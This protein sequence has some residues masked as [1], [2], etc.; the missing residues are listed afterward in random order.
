MRFSQLDLAMLVPMI[1]IL[2]AVVATA[3][4]CSNCSISPDLPCRCDSVCNVYNDCCP[5][6]DGST[7]DD[8]PHHLREI[9]HLLQCESVLV[10]D[11]EVDGINEAYYMI[12]S[13]TVDGS[14]CGESVGLPPVTDVS[15]RLTYR[16]MYCAVCSG[17]SISSV[18]V[19]ST[20]LVC[21]DVIYDNVTIEVL[22]DHCSTCSYTQDTIEDVRWCIPTVDDCDT[23]Q[24]N[25][26]TDGHYDP[27]TANNTVYRNSYCA[28][29]NGHYTQDCFTLQSSSIGDRCGKSTNR[30]N[31]CSCNY[32]I[33]I[34]ST[35]MVFLFS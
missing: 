20:V 5:N 29:C 25:N 2:C 18:V 13:C 17:V 32:L 34:L 6:Y 21:D 27:V 19:W 12:S 28:Q 7:S 24:Y 10:S 22:R 30:G 33:K 15:K 4:Y 11:D 3:S 9:H 8:I 1:V 23:Q 31:G 26:C 35:Q 16:N 14:S